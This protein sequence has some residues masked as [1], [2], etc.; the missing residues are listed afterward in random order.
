MN[1]CTIFSAQ[2]I[3]RELHFPSPPPLPKANDRTHYTR[4]MSESAGRYIEGTIPD[5]LIRGLDDL[6]GWSIAKPIRVL[7]PYL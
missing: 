2:H 1:F 5:W 3:R 4:N 7:L 6:G